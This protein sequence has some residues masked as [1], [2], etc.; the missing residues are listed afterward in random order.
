[1]AYVT[2]VGLVLSTA[3]C[4]RLDLTVR[5]VARASDIRLRRHGHH[6]LPPRNQ[7]P[8]HRHRPRLLHLC[9]VAIS[10]P[11]SA[12]RT[13]TTA[14]VTTE[15]RDPSTQIALGE[16]TVPTVAFARLESIHVPTL[17]HTK[18]SLFGNGSGVLS[19]A[20]GTA[21]MAD[22]AL[23]MRTVTTGRTAKIAVLGNILAANL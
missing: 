6:R 10:A 11:T 20:T 5:T 15:A 3:P 2:T 18:L 12:T 22:Q 4:A 14:Y 23:S 7:S 1:M 9:L 13:R 21:T 19:W 17:V 8:R 16:T